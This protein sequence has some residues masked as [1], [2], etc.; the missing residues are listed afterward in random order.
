MLIRN[1]WLRYGFSTR[2][3]L[4]LGSSWV[5]NQRTPSRT[6]ADVDPIK[7]LFIKAYSLKRMTIRAGAKADTEAAAAEGSP[8]TGAPA[9][10][11][12]EAEADIS[13]EKSE[14]HETTPSVD[15]KER[16][17]KSTDSADKEPGAGIGE[18]V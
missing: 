17:R 5:R 4:E 11:E 1:L 16:D 8:P 7:V 3:L 9:E 15:S 18:K 12:A 10:A 2:P 13:D 14:R 6:T